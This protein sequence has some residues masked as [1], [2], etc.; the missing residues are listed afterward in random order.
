[1]AGLWFSPGIT[2]SSTNITD[3]HNIV[4]SGVKHHQ[5]K[6][7]PTNPLYIGM[8]R[9]VRYLF[10]VGVKQQSLTHSIPRYIILDWHI[11]VWS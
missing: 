5:T 10:L 8:N 3:C 2:F 1:M 7:Q 11:I 4:E 9:D 6:P